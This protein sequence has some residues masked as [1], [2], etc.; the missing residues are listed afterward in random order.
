[1]AWHVWYENAAQLTA[2]FDKP[3]VDQQVRRH[4]QIPRIGGYGIDDQVSNLV[5][6]WIGMSAGAAP[7]RIRSTYPAPSRNMA[8]AAPNNWVR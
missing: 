6:N 5:E 3:C 2:I 1:V 8:K 4:G 7:R